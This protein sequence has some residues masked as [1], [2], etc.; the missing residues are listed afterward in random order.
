[1]NNKVKFIGILSLLTIMSSSPAKAGGILDWIYDQFD[2]SEYVVIVTAHST[3]NG[4]VYV[5]GS[6]QSAAEESAG[7]KSTQTANTN[8]SFQLT[9]TPADGYQFSKWTTDQS[10][11][12]QLSSNNPYNYT[13]RSNSTPFDGDE[14]NA[15]K[16][17]VYAHFTPVPYSLSFLPGDKGTGT[18]DPVSYDITKSVT[19]PSAPTCTAPGY[20]FDYWKLTTTAGNW[21]NT[22]TKYNAGQTYSSGKWGNA[23]FTA[24]WKASGYTVKCNPNGGRVNGYT[25][26]QSISYDIESTKT[27]PTATKTGSTFSGWKVTSADGNWALSQIIPAGLSLAGKYGN[28]TLT[29]QWNIIFCPITISLSGLDAGDTAIFTISKGG[30]VLYTVPVK[31]GSS[32]TIQN[33]ETGEYT[34]AATGWSWTYTGLDAQTEDI[35]TAEGHTF[36]FTA[37]KKTGVGKHD[38]DSNVNVF[39][40]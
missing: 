35:E 33:M 2:E 15:E 18:I 28:V 38:E 21:T 31:S 7:A 30:S 10:G 19:M 11:T 13:V 17:D 37:T 36:S 12:N 1:M 22:S 27:L 3:G 9:A 5:E 39:G 32:V 14:D 25:S 4:T 20:E 6:Q 34:V 40:N 29:A 24:Q 23:V 26:T 16:Y 8:V